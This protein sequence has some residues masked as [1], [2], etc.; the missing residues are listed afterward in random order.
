VT[1]LAALFE[2]HLL[3]AI[4]EAVFEG[5]L[6]SV[7]S[8]DPDHP[9]VARLSL[10]CYAIVGGDPTHALARELV[11]SIEPPR[12]IVYGNDPAWRRLILDVHGDRVS[13]R[14]MT[15]FDA[16]GLD[17]AHLE[18]MAADRPASYRLTRM[19]ASHAGRLDAE[20]QPHALQV[21]D[22]PHR[23]TREGLGF[24]TLAEDGTVACAAT[25]Y[26]VSARHLE[27]AI[28]TRVAH[29]GRGLAAATAA[30][31]MRESL[32]RGLVPEWSASNPISKRL[33]ARLG[34]RPAGECEVLLLASEGTGVI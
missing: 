16:S 17:P 18:R 9:T 4:V 28:A 19:D 11:A 32:A 33:A 13:D 29:R 6:G 22:G 2:R 34:Y 25:S 3:R 14:P 20:L 21:F 27:V 1:A 31:L 23:F 5:R 26:T 15:I 10:G 8:D 30:A 7:T 12:E 24:A